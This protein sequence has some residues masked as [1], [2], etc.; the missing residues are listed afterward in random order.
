MTQRYV[1]YCRVST[2]RQGKSGLGLEAQREAIRRHIG[3]AEPLAEYQEVESGRKDDR[4]ALQE[5]LAHARRAGAVLVVAKLDRLARSAAFLHRLLES[6]VTVEF[7]DL[8][9]VAGPTGKFLISS[10]A[11]VAE[12][13]A[14]LIGERTRAALAAAKARG[15]RLGNPNGAAALRRYEREHGNGAALQGKRQAA[16]NRAE[17][18]RAP[19]AAMVNEGLSLSGMA[20]RLNEEGAPSV[21]GGSWTATGIRRLLARLEIEREAVAA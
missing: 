19:L 8:P 3:D 18:W 11:A 12:L 7:C 13:E 6:G 14:G 15:T 16:D 2:D 20:R 5:A 9:Q 21:S 4:P 1:T 17:A 10:L